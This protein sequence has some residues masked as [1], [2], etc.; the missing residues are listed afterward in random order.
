MSPRRELAERLSLIVITD[1][2]APAGPLAAARAALTAGAPAI[3]LRWKGGAARDILE[4]A[5]ALRRETL[6]ADALLFVNDRVD[7]ALAAGADGVHLGDDDLPTSAVRRIVPPS[8]IIGRSVDT[9]DEAVA[10]RKEG[11]DYV[12][13]GPVFATSTKS[14]T[15]SVLGLAGLAAFRAAAGVPIVAIG[16]ITPA[17]VGGVRRAGADGIAVIGAVMF[18]RDPAAATAALLDEIRSAGSAK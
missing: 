13:A 12:G 2:A 14:D 18:A 11:A 5:R 1:P 17:G 4:L 8:F 9:P 6:E 10:A 3:Q 16:G 15:G 7:I